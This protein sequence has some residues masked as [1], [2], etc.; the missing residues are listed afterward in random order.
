M[1]VSTDTIELVV[2]ATEPTLSVLRSMAADTAR[3][4]GFG[5]GGVDDARLAVNEAASLLLDGGA[6]GT[7]ECTMTCDSASLSVELT[8][9]PGPI[10][11][12]PT[13][14]DGSLEQVVIRALAEVELRQSPPGFRLSMG[15][16]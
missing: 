14:W 11:W 16:T 5:I 8:A 2:P 6:G 7:I 4:A 13:D 1:E 3:R 9:D 10:S 15:V 12:P